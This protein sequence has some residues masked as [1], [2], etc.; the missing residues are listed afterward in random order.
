QVAAPEEPAQLDA[1]E[2]E[3][4]A[5]ADVEEEEELQQW[6]QEPSEPPPPAPPEKSR[7]PS[8]LEIF[9]SAR[10]E[11]S[12]DAPQTP[13]R[14]TIPIEPASGPSVEEVA[15]QF[16]AFEASAPDSAPP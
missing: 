11:E 4:A 16:D 13:Q 2:H 15:A 5:G 8:L 14:S 10:A 3:E 9:R 7:G 6:N 1:A 12:F